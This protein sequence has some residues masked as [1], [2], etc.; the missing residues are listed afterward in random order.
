MS[1]LVAKYKHEMRL[2]KEYHNQL[3]EIRGKFLTTNKFSLTVFYCWNI[4][5]GFQGNIRVFCRVRPVL[6]FDN[7]QSTVTAFDPIDDSLLF[8]QNDGR[9]HSFTLDKVFGPNKSQ[10]DVKNV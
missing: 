9:R 2:R 4:W 7:E 6:P 1:D 8:V 10:E 3:I 5:N